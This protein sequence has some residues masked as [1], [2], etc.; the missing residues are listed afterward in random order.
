MKRTGDNSLTGEGFR[1]LSPLKLPSLKIIVVCICLINEGKI[2]LEIKELKA[3]SA[4]NLNTFRLWVCVGIF[5]YSKKQNNIQRTQINK[6]KIF[7]DFES[8]RF[9]L[10]PY[11]LGDNPISASGVKILVKG[12]F[13]VL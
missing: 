8:F 10:W 3:S 1:R 4:N 13:F 12:S 6:R 7:S 11:N 2:V 9:K 5:R